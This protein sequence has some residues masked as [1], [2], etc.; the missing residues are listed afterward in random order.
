MSTVDDG[1]SWRSRSFAAGP[2][3]FAVDCPSEHVRAAVEALLVDLPDGDDRPL[4]SLIE[5]A[6]R[7]DDTLCVSYG[8]DV[9]GVFQRAN[10]AL[11]TLTTMVTRLS[12]DHDTDRL[13]LHCAALELNDR[14]ILISAASGT[15]KTTLAAA[16]ATNGWS[17][18][19]DE[20]V[21]LDVEPVRVSGFPKPLMIKMGAR[22]LLPQLG[23]HRVAI[24]VDD[25]VNWH[26]PASALSAP[27]VQRSSPAIVVILHR[28]D[29][30]R[31][32][33]AT[34]PVPLGRAD[35][36]VSLMAETLDAQRFGP[37]AV[38]VLAQLVAQ[39]TC[40][41]MAVGPTEQAEATLRALSQQPARPAELSLFGAPREP[42]QGEW[43]IP[44]SVRSASIDGRVVA[45]NS[46]TGAIVALDEV[47]SGVWLALLGEPP[48]WWDPEV[49]TTPA[50]LS[51]LD[52]LVSNTFL[53]SNSSSVGAAS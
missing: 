26:V 45:H 12:L 19:S 50:T 16:L 39:S 20:S 9:G 2:T 21:A 43:L 5:I 7:D 22:E 53:A 32:D 15:G 24:D 8:E 13:H 6:D 35:A 10:N 4:D 52:R 23:A 3:T 42:P 51:F 29:D 28:S 33:V 38:H 49:L 34:E 46:D 37:E 18:L 17:Y 11:S 30:G 25:D 44:A 47:G 40:V 31:T 36:V 27:V 14:G 41:H 1:L 48:S